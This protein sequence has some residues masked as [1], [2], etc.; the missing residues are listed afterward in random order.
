MY[1]RF[2]YTAASCIVRVKD[3]NNKSFNLN[4]ALIRIAECIK[5]QI[6]DS[7]IASYANGNIIML[8]PSELETAQD[9]IDKILLSIKNEVILNFEFDFQYGLS[10]RKNPDDD[11]QDVINQAHSIMFEKLMKK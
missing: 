3:E 6:R 9:I 7:D 1:R 4:I 11:I 8:F 10:C 5:K 2:P